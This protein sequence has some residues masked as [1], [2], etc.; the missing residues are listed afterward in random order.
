MSVTVK[1]YRKT[2]LEYEA[3]ACYWVTSKVVDAFEKTDLCDK[4]CV[5]FSFPEDGQHIIII[6]MGIHILRAFT[7]LTT[8]ELGLYTLATDGVTTDG[9]ATVADE[10]A[11]AEVDLITP[12]V[13]GW[14]FPDKGLFSDAQMVGA[15]IENANLIVGASTNVPAIV[16]SPK[17]ATIIT[18]QVQVVMLITVVPGS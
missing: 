5:L 14:Y 3:G 2:D 9:V 4:A 18:G 6:R 10:D 7:P 15:P 8:L 17:V 16:L 13:T 12:T 11:F 1:D